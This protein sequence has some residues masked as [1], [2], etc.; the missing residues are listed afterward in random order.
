VRIDYAGKDW[1]MRYL[2][3]LTIVPL[4]VSTILVAEEPERRI[5]ESANVLG[6][7]MAAKDRAIPEDLIEKARCMAS[8]LI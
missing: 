3:G 6:E 5:R 2:F 1:D 8:F 4:V 7:I